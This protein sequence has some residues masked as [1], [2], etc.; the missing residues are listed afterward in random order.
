MDDG[1]SATPDGTAPSPRLLA[2]SRASL[3][4]VLI[5]IGASIPFNTGTRYPFAP[6]DMFSEPWQAATRIVVRTPDGR[7][8]EVTAWGA[9]DC[10]EKLDL[11]Q[12]GLCGD[13][14][15]HPENA[16]KASDTVNSRQQRAA[17]RRAGGDR[18]PPVPL[19][20]AG[21]SAE[22]R[23]VRPGA[24]Q[25][26]GMERRWRLTL[27]SSGSGDTASRS[28]SQSTRCSWRS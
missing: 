18:P 24:L 10:A 3:A 13:D 5:A 6:F 12:R 14:F 4:V 9:W 25:S 16:H 26:G 2:A 1:R 21:R 11:T 19:S 22:R 15:G 7:L 27:G 17:R 20:A 28:G 8:S 23:R